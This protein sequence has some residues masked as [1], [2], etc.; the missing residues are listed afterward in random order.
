M[1]NNDTT[2]LLRKVLSLTVEAGN[3]ILEVYESGAIS[4]EAK[5]DNSP[6]TDADRR[7][8]AILADGLARIA[9]SIPILSEE[10]RT[11]P[12]EERSQWDEFWLVDPLDGT[13]E[14]I[15]RNG[16]FTVN[17]AL[18]RNGVPVLG[19]V[20]APVMASAWAGY[21]PN[22]PHSSDSRPESDRRASGPAAGGPSARSAALAEVFRGV[23]APGGAI[24]LNCA[25]AGTPIRV[26]TPRSHE[27][28]VV[29]SRSHMNS[30]TTAF[31]ESLR[32]RY[33]S[34]DL[35]SAGS[36]LKLCMVA[37]GRADLY[38]R[39]AP[40]SEWDTAAGHAVVR[41][42]GGEVWQIAAAPR[43][44]DET[45]ANGSVLA[46]TRDLGTMPLQYNKR[47]LLNPWFLARACRR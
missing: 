27:I 36:S 11:I 39:F 19:V 4:V 40:T 35:V 28:R 14:F 22:A 10:G 20:L 34:V 18:V 47:D 12:Y 13:K 30:A 6:L 17:V 9:P 41:A 25:A 21:S 1:I 46:E 5:A 31:V 2:R 43:L 26:A 33:S 32:G 8:H 44:S 3:A 29:A 23:R 24:E 42:A 15:K 16:E 37:D 38:P 45:T 7:S